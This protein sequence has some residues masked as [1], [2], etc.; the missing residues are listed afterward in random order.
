METG[1]DTVVN[2][3]GQNNKKNHF[4]YFRVGLDISKIVH[5]GLADN[6]NAYELL[7]ESIWK[8]NMHYVIEAGI[9]NAENQSENLSFSS[10][11]S[12]VRVGFD[13]Y[14]FDEL[15]PGDMD[16]AFIGLRIGGSAYRRGEAQATIW[17]PFYGNAMTTIAA[18][19][20]MVYWVG[21]T[22]G[23]RMEFT[24]NVFVG[25]NVRGKTF[26]NPNS[27]KELFPVY[28]AGYGAANKQPSFNYNLYLLYG[29]G[30][31]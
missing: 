18:T 6:Y 20:R 25:W 22:A 2:K 21:L 7:F 9:A 11:S 8:T 28:L 17:D 13:K 5:S 15:Y 10:S 27:I 26:I 4:R 24:R 29:F 12:F 14:F 3:I 19:N 30:R 16:N 31:R 1:T 23:F